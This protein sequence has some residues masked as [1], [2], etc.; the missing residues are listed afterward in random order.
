MYVLFCNTV[1]GTVMPASQAWQ[2]EYPPCFIG[3]FEH[4]PNLKPVRGKERERTEHVI[5]T[6]STHSKEAMV[7]AHSSSSSSH[8]FA[9]IARTQHNG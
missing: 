5:V 7:Q 8:L 6:A 1:F 3:P 2:K 4:K 9:C